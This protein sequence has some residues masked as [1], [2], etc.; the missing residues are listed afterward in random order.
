MTKRI[1]SF[2][3]QEKEKRSSS[4]QREQLVQRPQGR[5]KLGM[6]EVK[7]IVCKIKA[8]VTDLG[9]TLSIVSHHSK[10]TLTSHRLNTT[11][12]F[13]LILYISDSFAERLCW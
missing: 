13:L 9:N 3:H 2:K 12:V 10:Q 11:K 4:E 8:I 5:N 7:E 1:L 6:F